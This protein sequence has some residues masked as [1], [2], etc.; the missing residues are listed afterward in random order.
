MEVYC[1]KQTEIVY[2]T[3]AN[4]TRVRAL[5]QSGDSNREHNA[6]VVDAGEVVPG[7]DEAKELLKPFNQMKGRLRNKKKVS[8]V[9]CKFLLSSTM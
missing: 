6:I 9:V 1:R 2:H 4:N 5:L 7:S 3:L 8:S